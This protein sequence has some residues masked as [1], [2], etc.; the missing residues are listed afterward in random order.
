MN[1]SEWSDWCKSLR[2]RTLHIPYWYLWTFFWFVV[3]TS[4]SVTIYNPFSRICKAA[5]G[6]L[7]CHFCVFNLDFDWVLKCSLILRNECRPRSNWSVRFFHYTCKYKYTCK[8]D[9]SIYLTYLFISYIGNIFI[10][11]TPI[12][13]VHVLHI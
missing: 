8:I 3:L 5:F 13:K 7:L 6:L 12:Y 2:Q 11:Y 9:L 4:V 10:I 1:R